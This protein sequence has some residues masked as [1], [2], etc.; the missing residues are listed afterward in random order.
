MHERGFVLVPLAE[1][2]PEVMHPVLKKTI[3]ELKDGLGAGT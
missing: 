2:A 1:I 3:K